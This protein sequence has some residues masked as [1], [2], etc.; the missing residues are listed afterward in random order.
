[1]SIYYF[2]AKIGFIVHTRKEQDAQSLEL[3]LYILFNPLPGLD[4]AGLAEKARRVVN[5]LGDG[6]AALI[7]VH[8]LLRRGADPHTRRFG[9]TVRMACSSMRPVHAC[10]RASLMCMA[11]ALHVCTQVLHHAL[12]LGKAPLAQ[13]LLREGAYPH[14]AGERAPVPPARHLLAVARKHQFADEATQHMRRA[15]WA[16]AARSDVIAS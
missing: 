11:C 9:A 1:M 15:L 2:V 4:E 5:D 6:H 8:E 3:T 16:G 13:R 12:R 10:T 14:A 7:L